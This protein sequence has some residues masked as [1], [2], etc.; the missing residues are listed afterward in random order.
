MSVFIV[1]HNIKALIIAMLLG[2]AFAFNAGGG[3]DIAKVL[4]GLVGGMLV[5][6][7]EGRRD[8]RGIQMVKRRRSDTSARRKLPRATDEAEDRTPVAR[9]RAGTNGSKPEDTP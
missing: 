6:V 8:D 4:I 3:D 2:A 1:S 7:A 9:P 5:P